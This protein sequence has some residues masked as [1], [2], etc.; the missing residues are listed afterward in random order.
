MTFL[1]GTSIGLF[2]FFIGYLAGKADSG[3]QI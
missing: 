2:I 3:G 1:I